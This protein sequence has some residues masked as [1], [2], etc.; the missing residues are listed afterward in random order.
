[1]TSSKLRGAIL[2]WIFVCTFLSFFALR[3]FLRTTADGL[4]D[5]LF[6]ARSPNAD[7]II[8][9]IDDQSLNRLGQWPWPRSAFKDIIM[10]LGQ[11]AVIGIDVVFEE[12]SRFGA[13]DDQAFYEAIDGAGAPV[14][15]PSKFENDGVLRTPL[16]LF[17][18]K[19][20]NGLANVAIDADGVIRRVRFSDR[21]QSSFGFVVANAYSQQVR[22]QAL[23][24]IDGLTRIVWQGPNT[25]V[26]AFSVDDVLNGKV[27]PGIFT[28]KIVLIGV[29]A[30]DLRD[31]Q[32]TPVG[33]M[34]GVEIQ[35]NI[36]SMLLDGTF[37]RQDFWATILAI[38][39]LSGLT[40]LI[41]LRIENLFFLVLA[42]LS[43]VFVYNGIAFIAFDNLYVLDLLYAN[44]A[45]IISLVCSIAMEYMFVSQDERFIRKSFEHYV[46]PQVIQ[47][48]LKNPAKLKLGGDR[49]WITVLFADIRGS[50]SMEE[51]MDPGQL[52]LFLNSYF[53]SMGKV[54]LERRG[55]IDKYIGDAVMAFWGAPL[56]NIAQ[57][58]DAVRTALDMHQMLHIF[59]ESS[60]QKGLP[61]IEIGISINSGSAT[62]GNLGSSEI[63][64][65]T[66]IGDSVNLASR[67]E[68]LNKI[69]GTKII[70]S[71]ATVEGM[72]GDGNLPADMVVRQMDYIRVR[73][74]Q[75]PVRVF[76]VVTVD[77]R[78]VVQSILKDFD[79][80]R[81][82]YARGNWRQAIEAFDAVLA[83]QPGDTPAQLLRQRCIEF[84]RQP[85]GA[86]D[87]VFD[88]TS[89]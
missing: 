26:P 37:F 44:L 14:V 70:V 4:I 87:G 75:Q 1:M 89:I 17:K 2:I 33:L 56:E 72:R 42:L 59:N 57:A 84:S 3:G 24:A 46:S 23:P 79:R 78:P 34:S 9:K 27:S 67:L 65:Y 62:V 64:N 63:F 60:K 20:L 73:G 18:D 80:G 66:I 31:F 88:F 48:L 30:S 6:T 38:I 13:D 35:A 12:Q 69:Y 21:Q 81:D 61:T 50:T 5:R 22:K 28:G 10:K 32:K 86:W 49:K 41:A 39:V 82:D 11:P 19:A 74:R 25:T 47:E 83:V 15:L 8:L 53:S 77:D 85:P 16:S 40:V 55:L 58:S 36:M 51:S 29:T 7:V 71:E 45:V 68:K 52:T 76:E 43:L 54:I